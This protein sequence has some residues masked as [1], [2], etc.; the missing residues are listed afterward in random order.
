ATSPQEL[1]ARLAQA[2][3]YKVATIDALL[4]RACAEGILDGHTATL[5]EPVKPSP[6]QPYQVALLE[7]VQDELFAS[8][9]SDRW[10]DNHVRNL[11]LLL[12]LRNAHDRPRT[13]S[14]AIRSREQALSRLPKLRRLGRLR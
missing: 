7:P 2:T 1:C 3:G 9:L 14:D 11:P 4:C 8:L 6:P 13:S 10:S 5:V 12:K